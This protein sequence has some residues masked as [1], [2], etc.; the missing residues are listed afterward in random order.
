MPDNLLTMFR[1][2]SMMV[3]NYNLISEIILISNGIICT[4]GFMNS[5]EL[6]NKICYLY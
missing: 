5:R 1:T 4:I 6:G 2:I 3:P